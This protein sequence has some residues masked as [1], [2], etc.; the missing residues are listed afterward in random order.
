MQKVA[1]GFEKGC[2]LMEGVA[3][4]KELNMFRGEWLDFASCADQAR[5]VLAR[6]KGD[7]TEMK[8]VAIREKE[9]AER[10]LPIVRADS[11]IGFESSNQY[12]FVPIDVVEKIIGCRM[13]IDSLN[14]SKDR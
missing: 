3:P 6:D 14:G 10:F 4:E 5:F 11:R 2:V 13:I 8:S 1:D 9:R 12:F 7:R